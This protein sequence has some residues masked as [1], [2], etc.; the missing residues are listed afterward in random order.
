VQGLQSP[1]SI[2]VPKKFVL[3]FEE[4][5]VFF[6]LACVIVEDGIDSAEGIDGGIGSSLNFVVDKLLELWW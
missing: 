3:A 1:W 4:V 5:A 2:L 6:E